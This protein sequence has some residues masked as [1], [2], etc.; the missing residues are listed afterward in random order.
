[1]IT[2]ASSGIGRATAVAAGRRGATVALL[3]RNAAVLDE[4]AREIEGAGGMALPLTTDVAVRLDVDRSA[5]AVLERC[6]RIDTWV[7]NAGVY[8]VAPVERLGAE[9]FERVIQVN[10]L[11]TVYGTKAVLPH[12]IARGQGTLINVTSVLSTRGAP[13]TSA[14]AAS[15]H[16]AKG[17]T[18][19]LR[20]EIERS[21]PGISLVQILPASINTPLFVHALA[22]IGVKP[23]PLP[24]VY[25]PELVADAI[26]HAAEHPKR[27]I[28]VG[29][30][31]GLSMLEGLAPSLLDRFMTI[32]DV[33]VRAQMTDQPDDDRNNLFAPMSAE[34]YAVRGQWTD[35]ERRH[36]IGTRLFELHPHLG[37]ALAGG[38]AAATAV[39]VSRRGR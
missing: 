25:A 8:A 31:R 23:R 4:V 14:Y 13:F 9:I 26:L 15:K 18:E 6:G 38:A 32:A 36:S 5:A 3:A 2:G 17:F 24:P 34:T 39:A 35:E 20:I 29:T 21:H 37:R 7:N 1:M 27:D 33:G 22:R 10:Y 16:A 30:G 28:F 11:G 19:A 12:F